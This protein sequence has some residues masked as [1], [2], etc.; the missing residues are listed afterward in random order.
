MLVFCIFLLYKCFIYFQGNQMVMN[1]VENLPFLLDTIGN[2]ATEGS[3]NSSRHTR[4]IE[5]TFT[6]TGKLSGAIISIYM[7]EKWRISH[8]LSK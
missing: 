1:R 8:F 4:Y 2:A 3:S 7:L 6:D 5:L